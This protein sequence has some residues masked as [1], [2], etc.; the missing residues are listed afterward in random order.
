MDDSE[1]R[2]NRVKQISVGNS[3]VCALLE[4]GVVKML[5]E[6]GSTID[7]ELDDDEFEYVS[8]GLEF[9]L[10]LTKKGLVYGFGSNNKGKLSSL[11]EFCLS[12][13]S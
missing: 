7:F 11:N 1:Q 9:L 6:K 8:C 5:D 12:R 3:F 2:S 13:I 10:L 4:T